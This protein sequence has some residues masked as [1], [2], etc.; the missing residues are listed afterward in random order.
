MFNYNKDFKWKKYLKRGC[1]G[2][3]C[4]FLLLFAS[5]E[6][7]KRVDN[8]K[9]M[10]DFS[11]KVVNIG[12]Y[13]IT[14]Q[15]NYNVSVW[16]SGNTVYC[17]TH[18]YVAAPNGAWS[19]M[20]AQVS[21]NK[22]SA[23]KTFVGD[24][25]AAPKAGSGDV[26]FS[27]TDAGKGT[28]SGTIYAGFMPNLNGSQALSAT[29]SVPYPSSESDTLIYDTNGG[30][31]GPD[32]QSVNGNATISSTKPTR[33][34]YDFLYWASTRTWANEAKTVKINHSTIDRAFFHSIGNNTYEIM[35]HTNGNI[36]SVNVPIW[37]ADGDQSDLVWHPLGSGSWTR[38]GQ[39][40]NW[41][42]Q[43]T[44][45]GDL[46][47]TQL[48]V[49][50]YA[51]PSSG[52][53]V[54]VEYGGIPQ[55]FYPG[56]S[57]KHVSGSGKSTTIY[58]VWSAPHKY[59]VTYN[60][61]GG[62]Y[63][64]SSTWSNTATYD[65]NYTTYSNNNFFVRTGYTFVGWN[66]KADGTGKDWTG[67]INKPWRWSYDYDVTLYA[68]WRP[69]TY[70]VTYNGNGADRGKTTSS[71]HTYDSAKN[72]PSN[73]YEKDG[74]AFLGWSTSPN[75]GVQY[76]NKASVVNLTATNG[77]TVTL[78]AQWKQLGYEINYDGNGATGGST[79]TQYAPFNQTTT[80][81]K[82][83]YYKKGYKFKEWNTKTN[84]SGESYKDQQSIS[85]DSNKTVTK[86]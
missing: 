26:Q 56:G 31:G 79:S 21:T 40:Y 8:A 29:F 46:A 80:L 34:G 71:E 53:H 33:A 11:S 67:W 57:Y 9:A 70:T 59:K 12:G 19:A 10:T 60:G 25:S 76:G 43:V 68:Q 20:G 48:W 2:L 64:G 86:Q 51:Y 74:H 6:N 85:V 39:Y 58:A 16:R 36:G 62:L 17:K 61:N 38:D 81:N 83:G 41:G 78:Y 23:S 24:G 13:N 49:H 82:N 4:V 50:I 44:H 72:L 75:G 32:S 22:G 15:G 77:A 65:E 54:A 35:V 42:A 27:F 5:F 84:G 37:T 45:V 63:N 69:I 47:G 66:T 1:I 3:V 73:G 18:V 30:S 28:V 52:G 14:L 7:T 55:I